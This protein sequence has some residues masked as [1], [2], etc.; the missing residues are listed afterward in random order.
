MSAGMWQGIAAGYQDVEERRAAREAKEEELREKRKGL[1]LELASKYGTRGFG[2]AAGTTGGTP[3]GPSGTTPAGASGG[4]IEHYSQV[5]KTTF[6]ASDESISRVAG[7]AGAAGL[8]QAVQILEKARKRFA[9]LGKDMPED[10]V[11]DLFDSAVLTGAE[12]DPIDF[13]ALEDYIGSALDPLEKELLSASRATTG[14]AYFPEPSVLAPPNIEDMTR[15]ESRA[16]QMAQM[17]ASR[18]NRQLSVA[19]GEARRVLEGGS[20]PNA[21]TEAQNVIDWVIERQRLVTEALSSNRGDNA[22]PFGLIELYGQSFV[23]KQLEADPRLQ[24]GVVSPLFEN[25]SEAIPK[26]VQS[27]AQYNLLA[28]YG[29]FRAGEIV[30]VFNP[31]TGGYTPYKVRVRG[32]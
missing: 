7:T 23:Q 11:I 18:E 20:D 6:N 19:L 2:G 5:L 10:V 25:A 15:V 17:E 22:N 13:N 12:T 31:E 4:N 32:N 24:R 21:V 14:Q 1:A 16:I 30:E 27:E 8:A 9:E 3:A 29:I 26:R 28:E